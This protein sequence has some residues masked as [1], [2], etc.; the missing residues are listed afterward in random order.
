MTHRLYTTG[1]DKTH[2]AYLSRSPSSYS[3]SDD[4][5]KSMGSEIGLSSLLLLR[6]GG[7][8]VQRV[9]MNEPRTEAEGLRRSG[10]HPN[11][12]QEQQCHIN[13]IIH[14]SA[15][16]YWCLSWVPHLANL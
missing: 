12:L 11:L 3:F 13:Q 8:G 10:P 14:R 7:I 1:S 9:L 2:A 6:V 5:V 16:V 15:R 4:A